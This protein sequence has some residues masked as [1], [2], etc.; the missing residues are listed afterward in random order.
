MC[1]LRAHSGSRAVVSVVTVSPG[2]PS[3]RLNTECTCCLG[4]REMHVYF[5]DLA[6]AHDEVGRHSAAWAYSYGTASPHDCSAAQQADA[7]PHYFGKLILRNRSISSLL[8]I[9]DK[10]TV[11]E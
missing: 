6:P 5:F 11:C 7:W 3:A 2:W 8:K 10:S 4:G 1:P 9:P